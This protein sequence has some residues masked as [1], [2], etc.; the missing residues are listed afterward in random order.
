MGT[1]SYTPG[2]D[3]IERDETYSLIAS[4]KV[5]GTSVY[6]ASGESIGRIHNFM[7][8]KISGRV[9]Y[10]VVS[11][12]GF[13]GL[14]EDYFP[15]PWDTLAYDTNLGGYVTAV[16][17]ARLTDAPRYSAGDERFWN[18]PTYPGGIDRHWTMPVM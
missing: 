14:G 1:A 11:F 15:L 18:D 8:D 4:D 10:V 9:V 3:D 2:T 13:L 6:N 12:G 7:V 5:E 17:K 16:D